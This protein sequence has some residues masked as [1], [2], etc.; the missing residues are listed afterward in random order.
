[1]V[2]AY[3]FAGP[4]YLVPFQSAYLSVLECEWTDMGLPHAYICTYVLTYINTYMS[5]NIH[6]YIHTWVQTYIRTYIHTYIHSYIHAYKRTGDG[7]NNGNT[8]QFRNE[9]VY[10]GCTESTLVVS[11]VRY[12]FVC[13]RCV[14]P[15]SNGLQIV[16]SKNSYENA[17][18]WKI[19]KEDILLV[20]IHSWIICNQNGHF[21]RCIHSSSF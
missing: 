16:F 10:V 1:M 12:F 15:V 5:T 3:F 7:Q 17:A 8:R 19:F 9:T 14:V 21:V 11:I 20:R 18:K 6:T 13:W 4:A 2:Y